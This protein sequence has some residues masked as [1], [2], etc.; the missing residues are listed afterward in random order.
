[1]DSVEN[2]FNVKLGSSCTNHSYLSFFE[3]YIWKDGKTHCNICDRSP[4]NKIGKYT[5]TT[6]N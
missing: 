6:G 3:T 2:L 4:K 1:M 5:L